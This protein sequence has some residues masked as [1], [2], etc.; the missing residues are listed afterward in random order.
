VKEIIGSIPQQ[1]RVLITAHDAFS[2]FARAYGIEVHAP[3]GV[4]TRLEASVGDINRL[5][6]LIVERKV[7]ALFAEESVNE[8]NLKAIIQ[9]AAQRNWT[10]KKAAHQLY[11]D[12]MGNAGTYEGTYIGMIDH[13]ATNIARELGGTAPEKGFNG[14]LGEAAPLEPAP[15]EDSKPYT[16]VTTTAM[17]ADIVRQVAGD[18]AKV[19]VLLKG[20]S[21]PHIYV[22]TRDDLQQVSQADV[23]FYSGLFLEAR[24]TEV[25]EAEAAQGRPVY[26]VTEKLHET[27]QL[28]HPH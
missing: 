2:Y 7:H 19:R 22:P 20:N 6:D 23:V 11:S 21:D 18:K 5:V 3:Q 4:D 12:S 16:V 28:I 1:Q 17:V 26:A 10:V 9:G 24:M 13:N 27:Y 14:K 15:S 8:N 25:F